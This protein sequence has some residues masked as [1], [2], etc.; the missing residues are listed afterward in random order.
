MLSGQTTRTKF[1]QEEGRP[2]LLL[3]AP[4]LRA[5][6]APALSG[7]PSWESSKVH[8]CGQH[9]PPETLP[10]A[11]LC[12]FHNSL[13]TK[14]QA[15]LCPK[16]AHCFD[17]RENRNKWPHHPPRVKS[18]HTDDFGGKNWR[19]SGCVIAPSGIGGGGFGP[20]GTACFELTFLF[21]ER[22]WP[23]EVGAGAGGGLCFL[24]STLYASK[25]VLNC[26]FVFLNSFISEVTSR[27]SSGGRKS[28]ASS[29]AMKS[30]K[31][32]SSEQDS[33][34]SRVRKMSMVSAGGVLK[35]AVTI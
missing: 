21:F 20:E 31:H 30:P 17:T 15:A 4:V 14:M 2:L 7:K 35:A 32:A 1:C 24:Y 33:D 13:R 25:K 16:I 8:G 26:A 22:P 34:T 19:A 9:S 28:V 29:I 5:P 27:A 6:G 12:W 23:S 10:H 11:V 18:R 3:A